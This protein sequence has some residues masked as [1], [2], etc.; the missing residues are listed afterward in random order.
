MS[1]LYGFKLQVEAIERGTVAI[2]AMRQ[3]SRSG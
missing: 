2:E 1:V 3:S